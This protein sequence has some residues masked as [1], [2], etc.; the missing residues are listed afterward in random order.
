MAKALIGPALQFATQMCKAKQ[1]A[2]KPS[3]QLP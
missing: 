2:K 1:P 3:K